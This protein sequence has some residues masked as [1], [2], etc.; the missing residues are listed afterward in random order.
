MVATAPVLISVTLAG[1]RIWETSNYVQVSG[2]PPN[3]LFADFMLKPWIHKARQKIKCKKTNDRTEKT[4]KEEKKY[5]ARPAKSFFYFLGLR[6]LKKLLRFF[7]SAFLEFAPDFQETNVY[8]PNFATFF[9]DFQFIT[10]IFCS[11]C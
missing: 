3:F 9:G 11:L 7:F 10:L 8:E 6:V 5:I 4:T 2:H 1:N